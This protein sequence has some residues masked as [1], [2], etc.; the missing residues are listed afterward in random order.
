MAP[1]L[2]RAAITR[3]MKLIHPIKKIQRVSL[4]ANN[5]NSALGYRAICR[6]F[7]RNDT[8]ACVGQYTDHHSI[9]TATSIHQDYRMQCQTEGK[10]TPKV[11]SKSQIWEKTRSTG[12]VHTSAKARL[13]SAAIW[14]ISMSSRFTSINHVPYLPIVTNPENNPCIQTVIRIAT[15]IWPFVQWLIANLPWKYC[16]NPFGSFLRKVANRQT[17]NDDYISSLAEVIIGRVA[18]EPNHWPYQ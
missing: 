9:T 5:V 11:V 18:Q 12:T 16:A 14:R 13:T 8:Q 15:K 4:Q 6:C 7:H 1:Q 2:H 17:N 10:N 3:P